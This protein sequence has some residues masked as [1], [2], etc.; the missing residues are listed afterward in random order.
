MLRLRQT[1]ALTCVAIVVTALAQSSWMGV[2]IGHAALTL[3]E[4]GQAAGVRVVHDSR[5]YMSVGRE[6]QNMY[7]PGVAWVDMNSDGWLDLFVTNGAAGHFLFLNNSDGTFDDVSALWGVRDS[8]VG[9]GV[10]AADIDNDGDAD[11]AIGNYWA[12]P[13]LFLG[14]GAPLAEVAEIFGLNP[15]FYAPNPEPPFAPKPETMGM[16]FGDYNQDG[17]VD[18]YVANYLRQP[19]LLME[20]VTGD[21]FLRTNKVSFVQSGYGFQGIF[22]D[23][24]DDN[25]LDIFVTNDFGYDSLFENQGRDAGWTFLEKAQTYKVSGGASSAEDKSMGMGVAVADYDGDLDLD[26]FVTNYNKNSLFENAGLVNGT[27]RFRERAA[28]AGVE[29]GLNCWGADFCDLDLD[30][31]LDL[32][33]ASGYIFADVNP[34][35]KDLPNQ[36]YLNDGAPDWTFTE[37]GE[38]VGFADRMMG[39][40]LATADYDRD[41]DVDI[42]V[43]N[44]T[45]YE[46]APDAANPTVY[47]G[48]LLLYRNDQASNHH[49][50]NVRLEGAGQHTIGLGC[51]RTAAGARVYVS[52]GARVQMREVQAG[53]SYISQNSLEQEFGLGDIASIDDVWVRWLCGSVEHFT[54]VQPDRFWVLREGAGSAHP[55]PTAVLALDAVATAAGVR[56]EWLTS[57][58]LP[59]ARVRVLRAPA[60]EPDRMLP[61]ALS[62][63]VD[64]RQGSA[65]D[66]TVVAGQRYAYQLLLGGADGVEVASAVVYATA[67]AGEPVARRP[68]VGQNFPNPFNPTTTLLY[69]IP[70]AM[71]ARLQ[72]LD[73]RGRVVRTL[74]D[75]EVTA[76]R[77]AVAWDGTDGTGVKMASGSYTYLL[78]TDQ[79]TSARRMTLAK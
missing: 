18:L 30:G 14:G 19:D 22:C 79:G 72:V 10:A 62:V 44:N 6:V 52:S 38:Q 41:G 45:F 74:V 2:R 17:Y 78:V 26:I 1:Q 55:V 46:P 76:G 13:Q 54:G 36:L 50:V 31:D 34:Q 21:Y 71:H 53:S 75:A 49:W 69:E 8:R 27:W 73:P 67:L 28:E 29:Y 5:G 68:R 40:G 7:G 56:L 33:Q 77:H 12:E 23:F 60:S 39:R 64:G 35:P 51:N 43:G 15:L 20:S 32:L 48:H 11:L 57:L 65:L 66:P 61:L 16:S 9:N 4:V 47:A 25:D 58:A 70:H 37:V 24:D 59:A 3:T 42:A 63:T